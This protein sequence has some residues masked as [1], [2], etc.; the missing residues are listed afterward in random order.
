MIL[1]YFKYFVIFWN[2][3]FYYNWFVVINNLFIIFN[4]EKNLFLSIFESKY[5]L[6]GCL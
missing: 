3:F 5:F 1:I 2:F 4:F 6:D